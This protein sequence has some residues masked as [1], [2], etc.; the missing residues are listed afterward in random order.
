VQSLK[1]DVEVARLSPALMAGYQALRTRYSVSCIFSD[2]QGRQNTLSSTIKPICPGHKLIGP[3]VTVQ[4]AHSDLQDPLSALDAATPGD[5]IVVNACAETETAVWGGLMGQIA[6]RRGIAGAIIEGAVR[7]VDE[8]RDIPFQVFARSIVPR[9]THT[10]L[11]GRRAEI[12][13]NVPI[14]AGGVIISPGDVVIAD[15]VGVT[16]VPF[17]DAPAA[18]RAATEQADREEN[19]RS[20]VLA[21]DVSIQGLLEEFGRL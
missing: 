2:V 18:L 10:M 1:P 19:T 5:I 8:L 4:L 14:D 15:D 16:I 13:L 9:G 21:E 3:V 20:R 17:R 7:D 12:Q 6:H 11:S